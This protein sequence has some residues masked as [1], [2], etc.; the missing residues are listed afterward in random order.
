MEPIGH[1]IRRKL[2]EQGRSVKE[3]AEAI[4]FRR[5]NV[6]R[7]FNQQSID[8]ELL[9]AIS[10]YLHYDF[11]SLYTRR[12]REAADSCLKDETRLTNET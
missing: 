10:V 12:Y 3:F 11:F 1:L 4:G 7:I 9:L 8:T 5:S 6:Y 2:D